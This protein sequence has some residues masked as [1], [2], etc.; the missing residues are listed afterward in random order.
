MYLPLTT[1]PLPWHKFNADFWS[2]ERT[3][4]EVKDICEAH[5]DRLV[6]LRPYMIEE[7]HVVFITDK[8]KKVLDLFRHFHLQSLPVIDPNDG[9][10]VAQL[11]R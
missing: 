3:F 1:K 8:I 7:P 5:G 10:P 9:S 4:A 11:T 6:D 2:T